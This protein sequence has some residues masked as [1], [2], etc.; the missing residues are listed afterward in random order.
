MALGFSRL[1]CIESSSSQY[2]RLVT[3]IRLADS[4][5]RCTAR[6]VPGTAQREMT[7]AQSTAPAAGRSTRIEFDDERFLDVGAELVAVRRLLEHA[8][9]LR[10]VHRDPGRQADRLGELQRIGDAQLLLRL[11]AHRDHVAGL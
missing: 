3:P 6:R 2:P 4:A 5:G 1:V 9:E 8:F 10:S 11:L 7:R